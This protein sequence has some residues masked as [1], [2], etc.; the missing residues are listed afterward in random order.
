MTLTERIREIK[1]S[2]TSLSEGAWDAIDEIV[3]AL[4]AL[5]PD[6]GE[7]EEGNG[8]ERG[9]HVGHG[10]GFEAGLRAASPRG[11]EANAW[12][13]ATNEGGV[14][15]CTIMAVQPQITDGYQSLK[16]DP[17]YRP[18]RIHFTDTEAGK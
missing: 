1:F 10:H 17:R 13:Q 15:L 4:D 16:P 18:C 7:G 11:V 2:R 8:H 6:R 14:N 3:A 5:Q 12:A 9:Y